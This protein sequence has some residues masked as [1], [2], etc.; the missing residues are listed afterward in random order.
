MRAGDLASRLVARRYAN[1]R[2][3]YDKAAK[4]ELIE[5]CLAPG[6]SVAKLAREHAVNANLLHTW[7][8]HYRKERMP[9][10]LNAPPRRADELAPAF[11]PVITPQPSPAPE[12]RELR[13]D[14]TLDNG[15]Q[16]DLRC[17]SR[18]DVL[19]ILPVLASL[20]CSASTRR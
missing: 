18:D 2:C 9:P 6:A 14:I 3:I 8:G 17:L 11:I 5:A 19:A 20:P 12:S 15:T 16:A 4:R 1:G 10:L 7:I 13:L